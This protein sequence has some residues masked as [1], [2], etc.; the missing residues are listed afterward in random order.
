MPSILFTCPNTQRRASTG[1]ETDVR[2]LT[3][4]WSKN[5]EVQCT[6]CGEV[7][8]MSVREAYVESTLSEV[9]QMRRNSLP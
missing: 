6:L 1:I 5:L 8:K 7:H 3:A 4:V 9:Y 2:S